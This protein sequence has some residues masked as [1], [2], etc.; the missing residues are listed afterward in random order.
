MRTAFTRIRVP[1]PVTDLKADVAKSLTQI[2]LTWKRGSDAIYS[3][4]DVSTD[5]I[6]WIRLERNTKW[7]RETYNHRNVEPGS[8]F[9][10]RVTPG[11]STYGFGVPHDAVL[12]STK[13]AVV[14]APVR[15]LTVM[16]NGQDKLD[17]SW[18]LISAAND[19]GSPIVGYLIEVNTDKDN[20][21][22]LLPTGSWSPVNETTVS[23]ATFTDGAGGGSYTYSESPMMNAGSV[24]WFRVFAINSENAETAP[25]A[26]DAASAEHKMGKTAAPSLPGA[27]EY[28]VAETARDANSMQRTELG[29]DLLWTQGDLAAGDTIKGYVVDRKVNDGDWESVLPSGASH[30]GDDYTQFTDTE[31]PE[32][33]EQRAYRV[34][35]IA[36]GGQ[37]AWSN[38]AYNPAMHTVDTSH[39][40]AP[41]AVGT[42]SDVTVMVGAS[43]TSTMAVSSYF[44][45]ADAGDTLEYI[46]MSSDDAIATAEVN[47]DGMIVV[48]GVAAGMATITV[49]ATDMAGAYAMQTIMVT[50]EAADMTPTSPSN[51]MAMT[52]APTPAT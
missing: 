1:G 15:D 19:G 46:A 47:S 23:D 51:V 8:M 13:P 24:R 41:M 32:A 52:M 16:A 21:S 48:T 28:L 34:A 3:A 14:P 20:N 7:A 22:T 44:S 39:N 33:D 42:I 31:E 11:H 40:A 35:A 50:V 45:D 9:H 10:Y 38:T 29:V 4:I 5:Q 17:L 30:T 12:G 6:K 25:T 27:P 36:S 18:P 37:G 26:D 2:N 49:T 43:K